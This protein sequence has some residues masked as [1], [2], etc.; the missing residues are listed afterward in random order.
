MENDNKVTFGLSNVHIAKLIESNG[1]ITYDTPFA[2]PGAV[3]LT[4]DKEG[5]M[6][7]FRADNIDYYKKNTNNGYSGSLEVADVIKKFLK[8]I[9]GQTE[10]SNGA[11]IENADDTVSE[12]ALMGEIEG[13]KSKRRF[14]FYD[15]LAER[16]SINASTT[17]EGEVEVKTATMDVKISPRKTDKEVKAVLEPTTENQA[18][19]NAF[20]NSVY[21]KN[22]SASV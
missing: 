16:P 17:E 9:F 4:L 22:Q 3:N 7:I 19:Y 11:I 6:S 5:A 14:V 20:Y 12:F 21:E 18:V 10:D 8:D 15:V 13:D 1:A 2:L